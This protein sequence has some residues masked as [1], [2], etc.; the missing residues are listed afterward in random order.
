MQHWIS[1]LFAKEIEGKTI[2][3]TGGTGSFGRYIVRELLKYNPKK[4][5]VFSRDEDKQFRMEAEFKS[6]RLGFA[7][8][9]EFKIG[10]EEQFA[11][12]NTWKED[13]LNFALGDVRDF[14]RVNEVMRGVDIVFHAAALK[15]VP[16]SEFHP[17]EA[18]KTNVIGARNVKIAAINNNVQKVVAISTDKAVKP[19]NA[20]GMSKAIQEKIM[21][22]DEEMNYNTKFACVRY[23]NVIGS[24][25]SVI[26]FFKEKITRNE[27]LPITH[28]DMTR[29]LLTLEDAIE[30]VFYATIHMKDR[31][32]F[33][34]KAPACTI[35]Q[36]AYV[37]SKYIT[38]KIDYPIVEIG[39]RQG[40]KIH[41]TLI[42]EEE[43]YR[44]REEENYFVVYP[45]TFFL[46]MKKMNRLDFF[47]KKEIRNEYTSANTERLTEEALRAILK[48][49]GWVN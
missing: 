22:A 37:M 41:E 3:V 43:M 49:T 16:L 23:G 38:G 19:V 44:S 8:G 7:P 18:I 40:E 11:I 27:P 14:K 12:R 25:G 46:Q 5:I 24:R 34:K 32:V 30:L 10:D 9:D 6:G 26:P 47:P 17:F 35:P 20:M 48:E 28:K 1:E 36:L 29:F 21:L 42:S 15:Q 45:H 39:V 13:V 2:L 4:I 33:V 31:E